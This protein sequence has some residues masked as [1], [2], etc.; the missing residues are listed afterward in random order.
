MNGDQSFDQG[1]FQGQVL[2]DLRYIKDSLSKKVDRDEFLPVKAITY[3]LVGLI[4]MAVVG[5]LVATV[6]KALPT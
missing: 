5:A 6:V 4:L 1:Q 2:A 3:G